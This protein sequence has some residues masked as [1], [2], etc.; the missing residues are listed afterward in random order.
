MP[1][2]TVQCDNC[3]AILL[4]EDIFCGE[5]GAPRPSSARPSGLP[6]RPAMKHPPSVSPLR[7]A[8]SSEPGFY[9]AFIILVILGAIACLIGLATFLLFGFTGT[10]TFTTEENWLYATLLC[11]LPIGG[12]G[13]VLLG[14]GA[15]IWFTRLRHR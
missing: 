14:V 13:A 7:S 4:P 12:A 3:G 10:E 6:P 2:Q 9:W 8:K 15:F 1:E 11:L 5:C